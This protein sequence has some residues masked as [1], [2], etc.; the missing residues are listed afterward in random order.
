MQ[1][2]V[3]LLV[4]CLHDMYIEYNIHVC[5]QALACVPSCVTVHTWSKAIIVEI[6]DDDRLV[7]LDK[8]LSTDLMEEC[9]EDTHER[10]AWRWR[11]GN[12]C[13]VH[14]SIGL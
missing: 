7:V 8:Q 5:I 12:G 14:C 9:W 3:H 4:S 13:P 6:T 10:P 2:V 1:F 11:A